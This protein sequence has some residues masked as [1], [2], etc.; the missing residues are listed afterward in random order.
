MDLRYG[1]NP[2]QRAR[3]V[4]GSDRHVRVLHGSASMINYLDALNAWQLVAEA[5][6]ATGKVAAASFKH[7]SPAGAAVAGMLDETMCETWGLGTARLG[8]VAAAYVRARDADPRSSFGDLIAVSDPVDDE[9][10]DLLATVVSDGIIAPGYAPGTVAK[11]ARK[12][13]GRFLVVDIDPDF[14]PPA[15]EI[16]TVFGVVIEQ[17]HDREPITAELLHPVGEPKLSDSSTTDALLGMITTRFTQSNT[18]V[19]VRDG[20][21]VG[22]GAGQQSRIDC[23]HLA[24]AKARTWWMRRHHN[25]QTL[26]LPTDLP[27]QQRLNWQIALAAGTL[28]TRETGELT[29][30]L[31]RPGTPIEERDRTEWA[32]GLTGLTMVSDGYLPFR[33][34]VDAA[35]AFGVSVIVEP[36]GALQ[37]DTIAAACRDH[38]ISLTRTD[39][40]MFHH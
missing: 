22:V 25:I 34:N 39:L 12:K 32:R 13:R 15:T 6:R 20:M 26:P 8:P 10:A 17:D 5:R 18:V 27:R 31:T 38:H 4:D 14:R 16:R 23:T 28:T 37:H 21:T 36:T 9:L 35:A 11:L 2:H 40:R 29:D 33:D 30:L 1:M 3:I 7:V 24:G 19:L